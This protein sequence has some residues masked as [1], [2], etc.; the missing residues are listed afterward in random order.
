MV[1]KTLLFG[2]GFATTVFADFYLGSISGEGISGSAGAGPAQQAQC[3]YILWDDGTDICDAGNF[4]PEDGSGGCPGQ[5]FKAPD[6]C[7]MD[8]I[9]TGC[10]SG[11]VI[12]TPGGNG[13]SNA[14]T[15]CQIETY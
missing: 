5:N 12:G 1:S 8:V 13:K 2:L 11:Y 10:P 4:N 7:G 6:R 15:T 14:P 9:G 3:N